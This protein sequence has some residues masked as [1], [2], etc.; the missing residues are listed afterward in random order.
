MPTNPHIAVLE[1]GTYY[2]C[3]CGKSSNVP[4][5]DGSHKGTGKDPIKFEIAE[6]KQVALCNCQRTKKAPFCDGTHAKTD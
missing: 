1:P 3:G 6:K 2:W 4:F 5:C